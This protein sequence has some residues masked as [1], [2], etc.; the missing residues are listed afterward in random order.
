MVE[1]MKPLM[2]DSII[3]EE[4]KSI[5]SN[6]LRITNSFKRIDATEETRGL[7]SGRFS[8]MMLPNQ[9]SYIHKISTDNL[10]AVSDR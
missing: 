10:G 6:A 2:N 7:S 4:R 1:I 8:I 9:K 3:D 5:A